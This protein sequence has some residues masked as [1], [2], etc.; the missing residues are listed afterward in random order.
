MVHTDSL[1]PTVKTAGLFIKPHFVWPIKLLLDFFFLLFHQTP[2]VGPLFLLW[3]LFDT[4]KRCCLTC[5]FWGVCLM[6]AGYANWDSTK[7]KKSI[8]LGNSL[9]CRVYSQSMNVLLVIFWS[10][11]HDS[12]VAQCFLSLKFGVIAVTWKVFSN[13]IQLIVVTDGTNLSRAVRVWQIFTDKL[14]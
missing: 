2:S 14:M 4:S 1:T 7:R 12:D 10:Y 11:Y 6:H 13:I 8:C 5:K 9:S 3:L